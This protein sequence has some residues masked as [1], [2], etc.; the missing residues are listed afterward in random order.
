[1][2]LSKQEWKEDPLPDYPPSESDQESK[3]E[4]SVQGQETGTRKIVSS[5]Q[6]RTCFRGGEGSS[7]IQE[8]PIPR[9]AKTDCQIQYHVCAG[10][11]GSG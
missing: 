5:L 2:Q 11:S 3:Q 1:M 10:E 6:S 7:E 4:R 9:F 8:D